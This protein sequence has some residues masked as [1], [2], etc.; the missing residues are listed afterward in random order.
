MENVNFESTVEG[1]KMRRSTSGTAVQSR[2]EKMI[3][4]F[5]E[6]E[7][8][9]YVYDER[10]R[11]AGDTLIRPDFYLPEFDV[12]IEYFGMNT[13]EYR[14]NMLK[15]RVLYQRSAKKLVSVSYKDNDNLIEILRQKLSRYFRI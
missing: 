12:Y 5:L 14:D 3:A 1:A 15:K 10:Y 7:G 9:R 11:I 8:I 13:P 2:G 6:R 4:E